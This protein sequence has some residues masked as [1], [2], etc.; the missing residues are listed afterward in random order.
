M[1]ELNK[2]PFSNI[3][4]LPAPEI[5]GTARSDPTNQPQFRTLGKNAIICTYNLCGARF[6]RRSDLKRH[7]M[8]IHLRAMTFLCSFTGCARATIGFSR[9]DKRDDHERKIHGI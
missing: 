1:E 6:S 3:L 7:H 4:P 8:A 9:K 5:D 2:S